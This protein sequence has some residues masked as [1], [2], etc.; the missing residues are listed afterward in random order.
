MIQLA[1]VQ[2]H[3]AWNDFLEKEK[4]KQLITIAHNPSL[5]KILAKTFGY[6]DESRVIKSNGK[7]IGVFPA[8]MVGKKLVSMPHFS[9]GG[10][11]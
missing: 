8:V 4:S 11:W 6:K 7:M 10:P 2:D 5:G 1:D 3:K 9:Y